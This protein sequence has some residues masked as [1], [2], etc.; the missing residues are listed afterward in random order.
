ML[1]YE[2]WV[3]ILEQGYDLNI[4][5]LLE[6]IEKGFKIDNRVSRINSYMQL[7]RRRGILTEDNN[8]SVEGRKL[9]EYYRSEEIENLSL[10][11]KE[12]K[13]V[14][15]EQWWNAY[16]A[17]NGFVWEG[18][19]F[20][21]TRSLRAQKDKCYEKFNSIL[22]KGNYTADDL[23]KALELEVVSKKMSS[24]KKKTNELTY[25]HNSLTYLNQDDYMGFVEMIRSGEKVNSSV[26][27]SEIS[28][29]SVNI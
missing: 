21:S 23:I 14:I 1:T 8:I 15:F 11:Q 17:T 16:P 9:L 13:D 10:L 3:K 4:V 7:M 22:L 6:T 12:E 26:E 2:K 29:N 19:K 20:P 5:F 18:R 24:Y 25:M 27:K 28:D